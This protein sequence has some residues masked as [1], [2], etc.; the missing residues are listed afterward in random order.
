MFQIYMKM[1]NKRIMLVIGRTIINVVVTEKEVQKDF[2]A[3]TPPNIHNGSD[4]V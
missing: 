1:M 3:N 4:T 2:I